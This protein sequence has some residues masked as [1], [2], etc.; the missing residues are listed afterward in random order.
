MIS[1][2]LK[3]PLF[4]SI[5]LCACSAPS[6]ADPLPDAG[7]DAGPDAATPPAACVA[8]SVDGI[9]VASV[10][11]Y[12]GPPYALGYPPYAIDGCRLAYLAAPL[13]GEGSS[14]LYLRDLETGADTLL[15]AAVE[16][17]RRP[18]I[19]GDVIAWEATS[20]EGRVVRV[21]AGGETVTVTGAFHHAGE[22]RASEDG[23]VM[24]AWLG[25]SDLDD[26]DIFLFKLGDAAA[27]PIAPGPGQQR[28]PDISKTHVAFADFSEDPDGRFDENAF[29]L[30]DVVIVD[31]ATKAVAPRKRGGKQAFPLLGAEG[32][33]AY[34]AWGP[35]H[36]EPKF[37]AYELLVGDLDAA[38]GADLVAASITTSIPYIRPVARGALVEWIHWPPGGA[39]SFWR[40]PADLSEP[41]EQ[42]PGL[43]GLILFGPSATT[44]ISIV[45]AQGASGAMGLRGVAR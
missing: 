36:P 27:S 7:P 19:A 29:D 24:T 39:A 28:F 8:A 11:V 1:T 16:E 30:A 2:A 15:E 9:A 37:S 21:R 4:A 18:T 45:A 3:T 44:T 22:P 38:P 31:L 43:D 10:D 6:P 33:I 42:V 41:P 40:R 26:T 17:P 5:L 25:E 23:V 32:S 14:A 13:P 12:G 20:S 35:A 34:L